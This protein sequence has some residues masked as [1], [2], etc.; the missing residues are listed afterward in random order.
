MVMRESKFETAPPPSWKNPE[1]QKE[2]KNQKNQK[3]NSRIELENSR[4]FRL[5]S[6]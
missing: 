3:T 2:E 4:I 1:K 5:S 6:F